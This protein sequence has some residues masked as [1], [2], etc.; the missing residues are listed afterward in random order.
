[1]NNSHTNNQ[2]ANA[3]AERITLGA[4]ILAAFAE[5][6]S[7]NDWNKPVIGDGRT[8]AVVVHHVAS[9][10][11]LEIELAQLLT[12]GTPITGA[13]IEVINQMNADHAKDH[14]D[15]NKKETI[16]LLR[17]N[18]KVAA[19]AVRAFTDEDLDNSATV[20]LNYDAPLTAQFFIEDHALR[21]SFHHLAKIEATINQQMQYP[22][23]AG[24]SAA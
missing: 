8:I 4:N 20:S 9:V 7:D 1:M 10:Y 19:E 21:H 3:L 13:T 15:A 23:E 22:Q 18:S 11:P 5:S 2:R 16:Q 17:N 6:L 24:Q 12:S 14:A